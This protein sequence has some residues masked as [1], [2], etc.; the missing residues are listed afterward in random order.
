MADK[1]PEPV[2]M[3]LLRDLHTTKRGQFHKGAILGPDDMDDGKSISYYIT[4]VP[5]YGEA[6]TEEQLK[7]WRAKHE[8]EVDEA[9]AKK[10][11]G[12]PIGGPVSRLMSRVAHLEDR[13]AALEQKSAPKK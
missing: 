3:R 5:Q 12:N 8:K 10:A 6:A 2:A 7:A 11:Q 4:S 13:I 9:A 1:K